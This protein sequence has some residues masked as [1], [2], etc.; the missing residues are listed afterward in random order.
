M[1]RV[2][3]VD[4]VRFHAKSF[5]KETLSAYS[6]YKIFWSFSREQNIFSAHFENGISE[7]VFWVFLFTNGPKPWG[8]GRCDWCFDK[9]LR[10]L[11]FNQS[12]AVPWKTRKFHFL[13]EQS[14]FALSLVLNQGF[15]F[16]GRGLL[17]SFLDCYSWPSTKVK[18]QDK[19]NIMIIH[20]TEILVQCPPLRLRSIKEREGRPIMFF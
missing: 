15:H 9:G 11:L 12:K 4:C 14:L 18:A 8:K 5:P 19:T 2:M 6:E 1:S 17:I 16:A 10:V 20:R 13:Q 7:K 3:S